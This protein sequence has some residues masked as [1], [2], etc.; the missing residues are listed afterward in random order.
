MQLATYTTVT[1]L[2]TYR[3]KSLH[4]YI[5]ND[6]GVFSDASVSQGTSINTDNTVLNIFELIKAKNIHRS[7]YMCGSVWPSGRLPRLCFA[8]KIGSWNM[9]FF[10]ALSGFLVSAPAPNSPRVHVH[11]ATTETQHGQVEGFLQEPRQ[12]LSTSWLCK[13]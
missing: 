6:L 9:F 10:A 5:G 3:M 7:I 12:F 4:S 2:L 11:S 1:G 8:A 13:P